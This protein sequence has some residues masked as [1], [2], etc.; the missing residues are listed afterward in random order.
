MPSDVRAVVRAIAEYNKGQ[1]T[2]V[3]LEGQTPYA[4]VTWDPKATLS[5]KFD[6][7]RKKLLNLR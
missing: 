3:R 5:L 1:L 6:H 4:L 7:L 2:P